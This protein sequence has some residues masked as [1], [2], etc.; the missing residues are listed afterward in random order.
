[1][2]IYIYDRFL[3]ALRYI[4]YSF[5]FGNTHVL[6]KNLCRAH[7]STLSQALAKHAMIYIF[8][9]FTGKIKILVDNLMKQKDVGPWGSQ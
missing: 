8:S 1:M 3:T 7:D 6:N 2:C 5:R 9:K 4:Q